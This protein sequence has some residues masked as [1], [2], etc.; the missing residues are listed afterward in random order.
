[1]IDRG[2]VIN[3]IIE[4]FP[5]EFDIIRGHLDDLTLV[6][7]A[8]TLIDIVDSIDCPAVKASR[9]HINLLKSRMYFPGQGIEGFVHEI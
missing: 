8:G 2:Q 1:L 3:F 9:L 7:P 5:G 4:N 6:G